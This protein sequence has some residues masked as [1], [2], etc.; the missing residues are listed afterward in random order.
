MLELAAS[1]DYLLPL[2]FV[3]EINVVG[4]EGGGTARVAEEVIRLVKSQSPFAE[5]R[6]GD[7]GGQ[8]DDDDDA[9]EVLFSVRNERA[10]D[11]A[12][13]RKVTA[14]AIGFKAVVSLRST[15]QAYISTLLLL[16]EH[17]LSPK[18]SVA[19]SSPP[20]V[21][22]LE[23]GLVALSGSK[24]QLLTIIDGSYFTLAC[25][26]SL[27]GDHARPI[28]IVP[29][30]PYKEGVQG[31][32]VILERGFENKVD[33]QFYCLNETIVWTDTPSGGTF[34]KSSSSGI[35]P[36]TEWFTI[37]VMHRD[38]RSFTLTLPPTEGVED[39]DEERRRMTLSDGKLIFQPVTADS[40]TLLWRINPICAI[41]SRT[42]VW[43]FFKEDRKLATI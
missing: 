42:D 29:A 22:V 41:Q 15:L 10:I 37:D 17:H 16:Q 11:D 21:P 23:E 1:Q 35:R 36:I 5:V 20:S 19:C 12:S 43:D 3:A 14:R 13:S 8:V 39:G 32:T 30:V 33:V 2:A 4:I 18:I 25:T 7:E 6:V 28:D 34:A 31:V 24:V 38:S 40:R 9:H 26:G 27:Q